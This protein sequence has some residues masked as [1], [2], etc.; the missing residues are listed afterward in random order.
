M[1]QREVQT[2]GRGG[3]TPGLGE[4]DDEE[5]AG[6]PDEETDEEHRRALWAGTSCVYYLV[7]G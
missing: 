3:V 5:D 2:G 6:V 1:K 7:P 4:D